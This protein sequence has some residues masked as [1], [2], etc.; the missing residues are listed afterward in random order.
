MQMQAVKNFA[1]FQNY[2][3]PSIVLQ[4]PGILAVSRSAYKIETRYSGVSQPFPLLLHPI[5]SRH[6]QEARQPCETHYS[7]APGCLR[8][9]LRTH[10][11][12]GKQGLPRRAGG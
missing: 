3:F 10:A 6:L 9:R 1:R 4:K 12:C 7:I 11:K 8:K 2:S 5:E